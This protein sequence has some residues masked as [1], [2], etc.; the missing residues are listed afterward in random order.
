MGQ[1]QLPQDLVS[2]ACFS[3]SSFQHGFFFATFLKRSIL[4]MTALILS[5]PSLFYAHIFGYV[6]PFMT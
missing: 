5:F 4:R 3:F 2:F 1:D 6:Q